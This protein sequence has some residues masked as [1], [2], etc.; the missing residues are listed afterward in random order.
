MSSRIINPL[1][2]FRHDSVGITCITRQYVQLAGR[3][4]LPGSHGKGF[5]K[6]LNGPRENY[7]H[8]IYAKDFGIDDK[9][10]AEDC[11]VALKYV[12]ASNL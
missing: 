3:T 4:S 7:P 9:T 8:I 11:A 5:P 6:F 10:S 12:N 2:F 1:R